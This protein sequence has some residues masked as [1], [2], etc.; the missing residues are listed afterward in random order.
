MSLG[1]KFGSV[2]SKILFS[3]DTLP[4]PPESRQKSC[5]LSSKLCLS[6]LWLRG[7]RNVGPNQR[8]VPA[9]R[10]NLCWVCSYSSLKALMNTRSMIHIVPWK[11]DRVFMCTFNDQSMTIGWQVGEPLWFYRTLPL[12]LRYPYPE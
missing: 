2:K 5:A 11:I 6:P 12:K 9:C 7:T 1:I 4:L 10:P 8:G 3:Q